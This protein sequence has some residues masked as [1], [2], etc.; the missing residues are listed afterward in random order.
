MTLRL[1]RPVSEIPPTYRCGYDASADR[2][3]VVAGSLLEMTLSD[4]ENSAFDTCF[5]LPL[6]RRQ[7]E[8]PEFCRK[9][10][11]FSL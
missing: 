10:G 11:Y 9:F 6:N 1:A 3:P 2:R 5:L 8:F 7:L 4:S